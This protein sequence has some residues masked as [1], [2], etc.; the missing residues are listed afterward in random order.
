MNSK[1]ICENTSVWLDALRGSAAQLVVA[2]HAISLFYSG[3]PLGGS[4]ELYVFYNLLYAISE[5]PHPAV[6]TFFVMSGYLVGGNLLINMKDGCFNLTKYLV[7]RTSRLF[8]VLFPALVLTLIFDSISFYYGYGYDNLIK[9]FPAWWLQLDP[10]GWK[11]FVS[12]AF[13]YRIL[14]AFNT[15]QTFHFGVYH[16]NFGFICLCHASVR[17]IFMELTKKLLD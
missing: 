5:A 14:L 8:V 16:L 1:M 12:N 13:F 2:G 15:E 3:Y 17:F 7:D 10:W 11:T 6:V 9:F 4:D